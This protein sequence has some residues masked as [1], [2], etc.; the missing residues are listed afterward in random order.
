MRHG[1]VRR[2]NIISRTCGRQCTSNLNSSRR[3]LYVRGFCQLLQVPLVH[4]LDLCRF[5]VSSDATQERH[6]HFDRSGH[7][8]LTRSIDPCIIQVRGYIGHQVPLLSE[9]VYMQASIPINIRTHTD[10]G[11]PSSL[12]DLSPAVQLAGRCP[13]STSIAFSI[14]SKYTRDAHAVQA[15]V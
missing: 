2:S 8:C 14:R 5:T 9:L 13:S 1:R 4:F 11:N 3:D 15:R 6:T 7:G 10:L 12:I